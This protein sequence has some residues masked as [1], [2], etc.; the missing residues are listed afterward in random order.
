[1]DR[2]NRPQISLCTYTYNDGNLLDGLLASVPHWSVYPDEI[3][4]VD[5]G[6]ETP[7]TPPTVLKRLGLPCR[8]IRL[9]PNRGFVE[10]KRTGL[11]AGTGGVLLSIDADMRLSS[12][13]LDTALPYVMQ[14]GT[15]LVGGQIANIEDDSLVARYQKYFDVNNLE[16]TGPVNFVSGNAFLIRRSVW[17]ESGGFGNHADAVCE[18][19]ALC[20]HVKGAGYGLVGVKEAVSVQSRR[21]S[22]RTFLKRVWRWCHRHLKTEMAQMAQGE[23]VL[24]YCFRVLVEPMLTRLHVAV[25]A[26]EPLFAYVELLYLSYAMRDMLADAVEKGLISQAE[27]EGFAVQ[28]TR[29]LAPTP[30]LLAMLKRDLLE[31]GTALPSGRNIADNIALAEQWAA[32]FCFTD[33][34]T[35]SGLTAWLDGEGVARLTAEDKAKVFDFSAYDRI[36]SGLAKAV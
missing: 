29:M 12:D 22:R 36:S 17:E 34:L 11:N 3:V 28:M 9:S 7:Y 1:M 27:S 15:G 4:I 6:S 16:R 8:V 20:S 23:L 19:H 21:L 5:D 35:K 14:P 30:R 18:D 25:S 31:M 13:W 26:G 33:A 32:F 2:E 24:S 10:A